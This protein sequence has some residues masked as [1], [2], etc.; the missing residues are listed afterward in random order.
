MPAGTSTRSALVALA[1]A[2][3]AGAAERGAVS[4]AVIDRT[5]Q[6]PVE[7]VAVAVHRREDGSR[8]QV[9]AT[10]AR[11]T[12]EFGDLPTGNYLLVY[13]LVGSE[14]TE[15]V[16]F[17]IDAPPRPVDLGRLALPGDLA[18]VLDPVQVSTRR[19]AWSSAI[20]R[21]VYLVG[22]DL[23][24]ATGTASDLLRNV[25]SV[26]VDLEG[27][28]SLRGAG[29]VLVLINGKT[30]S[31]LGR[32]R[33]VGL[34]QLP[35]DTIER[36]EVITNP[37]AKYRPDGTAG[38]INLV[39]KKQRAPGHSGSVRVAGGNRE[40]ANGTTM[41]N[42]NPGRLN[43]FGSA[44]VRQDDR[45]RTVTDARARFDAGLNARVATEQRTTET[46]RPRSHLAR[47]GADWRI[48]ERTQVGVQ[49]NYNHREVVRRS[50][51]ATLTRRDGNEAP[52]GDRDRWR[53][54]PGFEHDLEVTATWQR[55]FSGED[56][57]FN[58]EVK[59]D[60]TREQEDNHY[61]NVFRLPAAATA[62][63][64]TLIG[65]I[66]SSTELTAD[67][68]RPL[69]P[70]G[71]LEAGFATQA[72]HID[73]DYRGSFLDPTAGTW[74]ADRIRNNRFLFDERILALYMTAGH[75]LGRWGVLAGLRFEWA[76]V[77]T[78]QVTARLK[79][80]NAY[81]RFYPSLH[82][83][84]E[85]RAH[86]EW[87]LNYSHRVRR[88]DGDD[89]NPFPTF[90][91]PYHLRAGNPRLVPEDIHSIETGWQYQ[92]DDTTLLAAVYYRYRYHGLTEVTRQ[93]DSATLFT[94]K[95]N[96]DRSQSGGLELSATARFADRATVNFSANVYRNEI[97]ASSLGFGARRATLTGEAKLALS[98]DVS[99]R[100]LLQCN[101]N[102]TAR[103]LTP[104]GYRSP[105]FV[106]N[107]GLRRHLVDRR[108]DVIVSAS[109]LFNSLR[110]RTSL[111]SP[112]LRQTIVRRRSSGILYV[113]L[114][115][116]FGQPPK[117]Q[118][119]DLQFDPAL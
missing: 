3:G 10:N 104:Q 66:E 54:A 49:V 68:T 41:A 106:A 26:Q 46:A 89:L 80:D 29:N 48:D 81:P 72:N 22:K 59:H 15:S 98:W 13:G 63:E 75:K 79:A 45:P 109:D 69:G 61:T 53:V 88:P 18:V 43:L 7:Y 76:G 117:K 99:K 57:E 62:L 16:A 17:A 5:S 27:N 114:I 51:V 67:Y 86:H 32:N 95:E 28:V 34:E 93:L 21:K 70:R 35:A 107:L 6:R 19:E 12:F 100:T 90:E 50:A 73:L 11:G 20:D 115:Y 58:L 118:K 105:T 40:R 111:E 9:G 87:Q 24:S 74:I 42:Y 108:L 110:E 39:L 55:A 36:I 1:L 77:E 96:L 119:D 2:A 60:R 44:S 14:R 91:D 65:T 101:A 103:R 8:L 31:L 78:D 37:S 47:A 33:A 82:L 84:H 52:L 38:I 83:S 23:Q 85:L 102:Y 113:G 94:T 56:H 4:G 116:H 25:P 64:R 92:Q 30:T 112:A 97:E 71:K